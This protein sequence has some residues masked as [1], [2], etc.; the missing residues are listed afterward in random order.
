MLQFDIQLF[1]RQIG[2]SICKSYYMLNLGDSVFCV[3]KKKRSSEIGQNQGWKKNSWK[4]TP[5]LEVPQTWL[6]FKTNVPFDNG[7]Q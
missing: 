6:N 3:L 2:I 4:C 5:K 1:L 7:R